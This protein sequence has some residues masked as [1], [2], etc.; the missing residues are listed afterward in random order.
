MGA[1]SFSLAFGERVGTI[2]RP[3]H[4]YP[5]AVRQEWGSRLEIAAPCKMSQATFVNMSFRP[6]RIEVGRRSVRFDGS[7]AVITWTATPLPSGKGSERSEEHTSEL[8]SLR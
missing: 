8:Q 6:T 2:S 4:T 3:R 5:V 7:L 1:P